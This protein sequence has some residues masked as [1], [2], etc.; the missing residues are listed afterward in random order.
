MYVVPDKHQQAIKRSA[1]MQYVSGVLAI[2]ILGNATACSAD[3]EQQA[4][5]SRA[6]AKE[7]AEE[8]KGELVAA[9]QSGGPIA[10]VAVCNTRAPQIAAQASERTGWQVG[11]TSLKLRNPDN[12]P[13]AWER[14]VLEDFEKRKA[15]GEDPQTLEYYSVVEQGGKQQFRYMKAI[16]TGEVCLTCHGSSLQPELVEK[17]D[18]LYPQDKA[19]DF[20]AGDIRGAFTIIGPM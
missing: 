10:A 17:L 16:P 5:D 9:L 7:F 13:D 6:V 20:K 8:L 19:R 11:R 3:L 14:A 12:A 15:A 18:A 2:I 1:S 4:T